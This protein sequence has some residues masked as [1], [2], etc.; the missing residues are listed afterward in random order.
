MFITQ[1][2][3]SLQFS[4]HHRTKPIN[5]WGRNEAYN[6]LNEIFMSPLQ[7]MDATLTVEILKVPGGRSG[8]SQCPFAPLLLGHH[9]LHSLPDLTGSLRAL[10]SLDLPQNFSLRGTSLVFQWLGLWASTT[11]GVRSIPGQETKIP[12]GA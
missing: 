11:E 3:P 7:C 2:T 8:P 9:G 4:Q 12:H 1:I 6:S 5:S 10:S